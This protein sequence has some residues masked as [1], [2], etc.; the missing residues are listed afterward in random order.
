M[1]VPGMN[2][3]DQQLPERLVTID[4]T[5]QRKKFQVFSVPGMGTQDQS[6]LAWGEVRTDDGTYRT[7][8][9]GPG[10]QLHDY[11]MRL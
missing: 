8:F 7:E 2:L 4:M 10:T 11:V 6:Q 5:E 1:V 3:K 9:L